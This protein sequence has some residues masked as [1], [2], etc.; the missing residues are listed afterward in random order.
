[1]CTMEN[2]K[3]YSKEINVEKE[4]RLDVCVAEKLG[5]SRTAAQKL[6]KDGCVTEIFAGHKIVRKSGYKVLPEA[7]YRIRIPE[8]KKS[9]LQPDDR[10]LAILYEDQDLLVVDKPAGLLVHP[11][12]HTMT[13]TLVNALLY[14]VKNLSGIGGQ[15]RP[16]IVHRL[17]KDTSGVMVI[18]KHDQA[19]RCLSEQFAERTIEKTYVALVHGVVEKRGHIQAAI[20]RSK[21]VRTKMSV[22]SEKGRQAVTDYELLKRCNRC[23]L[24]RIFPRTGRTHQIRV[25]FAYIKHPVVGDSVY[26]IGTRIPGVKRQ[27]LHAESITFVHPGTG[28]KMTFKAPLPEDFKLKNQNWL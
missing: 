27:L 18:A 21:K 23:S 25:H 7:L 1:M 11:T 6:I 4:I 20:G 15:A 8:I 14:H 17:D 24:V 3:E 13:G 22:L 19:H 26:G 9:I 10:P 2:S 28:E 5:I 12:T 16:G